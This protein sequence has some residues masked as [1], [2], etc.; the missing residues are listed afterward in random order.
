MADGESTGRE[1]EDLLFAAHMLAFAQA[2]ALGLAHGWGHVGP[3]LAGRPLPEGVFDFHGCLAREWPK[4][5]LFAWVEDASFGKGRL[6]VGRRG[7][8]CG[9]RCY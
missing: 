8:N 7:D 9:E 5:G 2:E 4:A 1:Q 6:K 3:V